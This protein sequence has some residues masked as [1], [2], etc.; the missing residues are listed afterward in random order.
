MDKRSSKVGDRFYLEQK[1]KR[2][3]LEALRRDRY[4][5]Q[6]CGAKCLG[7]KRGKPSPEVDHIQPVKDRPDLAYELSNLRTLCKSCH[8]RH[9]LLGTI[10]QSKPAIGVD[11]YPI[12]E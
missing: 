7:K 8:S 9:T 2:V 4:I 6:L 5:C 11:G 3:R 12:E 10:G 1:W